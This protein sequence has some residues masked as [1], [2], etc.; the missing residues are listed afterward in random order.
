MPLQAVITKEERYETAVGRIFD[1]DKF[2]YMGDG[3]SL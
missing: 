1:R 2:E 3:T